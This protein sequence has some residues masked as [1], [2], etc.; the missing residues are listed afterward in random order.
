MDIR[1]I[2]ESYHVSPQITPEDIAAIA[3]AGFT[4]IICNRPD[5]EV[6]PG[7]QAA[8]VGAVAEAQGLAFH[9]LPLTHL[10]MTPEN[11]ARQNAIVAEAGG[12][13]LAY[14][15]SGTRCTVIWSLAQA[16]EGTMSTDDILGHAAAAGYALDG[17]RPQLDI[18][19]QG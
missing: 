19:R 8:A 11:V 5:A 7:I 2:N 12:P 1:H 10:T 18:I 16:T 15:A 4:A 14:C 6:P 9:T 3:A 13:V 17:L